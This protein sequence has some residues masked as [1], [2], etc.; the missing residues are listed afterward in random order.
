MLAAELGGF[1]FFFGC[2][3][4]GMPRF[5]ILLWGFFVGA[6]RNP[7]E[8]PWGTFT[9]ETRFYPSK[10]NPGQY[11]PGAACEFA[12]C[13]DAS[14][15][16][17]ISRRTY[18]INTT[19]GARTTFSAHCWPKSTWLLRHITAQATDLSCSCFSLAALGLFCSEKRLLRNIAA[20]ACD[21]LKRCVFGF[22]DR[23]I[24]AVQTIQSLTSD[25]I[26]CCDIESHQGIAMLS[27]HVPAP[28]TL[29]VNYCTYPTYTRLYTAKGA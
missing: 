7:A 19:L 16:P 14:S 6:C 3:I 11:T 9:S 26:T 15:D 10:A 29:V 21:T 5:I 27:T 12:L 13:A 17:Q 28:W 4:K 25:Y 20:G 24:H 18:S 22:V 23:F 2:S 8:T 1:I